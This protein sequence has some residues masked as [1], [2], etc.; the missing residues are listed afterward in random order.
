MKVLGYSMIRNEIDLLRY[1]IP[2]WKKMC[3]HLLIVDDNSTDG[4]GDYLRSEG[5]E[6]VPSLTDVYEQHVNTAHYLKDCKYDWVIPFD[7]DEL[8][9]DL[10]LT[11]DQSI[12]CIVYRIKNFVPSINFNGDL[13][14]ITHSVNPTGTRQDNE[15]LSHLMMKVIV[16]GRYADKLVMGYHACKDGI[17]LK[18]PRMWAAHFPVTSMKKLIEKKERYKEVCDAVLLS[19]DHQNIGHADLDKYWHDNTYE[20]LKQHCTYDTRLAERLQDSFHPQ[21]RFVKC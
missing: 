10:Y 1:T 6:V 7:A 5:V 19:I 3:D 21:K 12:D 17:E 11:D 18:E 8:L 13:R 9:F 14:T 20:H 2:Y 15:I 16:R 4:S